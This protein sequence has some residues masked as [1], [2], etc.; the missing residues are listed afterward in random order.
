MRKSTILLIFIL[1]L[2]GN[3]LVAQKISPAEAK[4]YF[5][6]GIETV[7]EFQKIWNTQI[8]GNYWHDWYVIE[9]SD[10]YC[11]FNRFKRKR[12]IDDVTRH[13]IGKG[14]CDWWAWPEGSSHVCLST[15]NNADYLIAKHGKISFI[16]MIDHPTSNCG[17]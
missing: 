15:P 1:S 7:G 16:R 6:K 12:S 8:K 3:D 4:K 13:S 9:Y 11:I 5:E 14:D 10:G 17:N 2:A